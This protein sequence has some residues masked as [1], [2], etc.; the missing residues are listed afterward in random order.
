LDQLANEPP[1]FNFKHQYILDVGE[2][3]AFMT[4]LTTYYAIFDRYFYSM[5]DFD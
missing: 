3:R 2:E 1:A 5:T 4:V